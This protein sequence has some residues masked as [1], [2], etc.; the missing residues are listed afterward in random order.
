MSDS[1]APANATNLRRT[2]GIWGV[3]GQSISGVAPTATPTINIALVFAVAG[4]GSWLAYV[5]ATVAILLVA[6]NLVPLAHQFSGAGSLSEFVGQGLGDHARRL[7]AWS[8]LL[9]YLSVSVATL[10]GS[11]GYVSTLFSWAG[12]SMPI[13]AWAAMIGVL[14]VVFALRNIRFS[15]GLMLALEVTSVSLVIALGVVILLRQG[16]T[17]DLS[18]FRLEGLSAGGLNNAL[19][20]GVLSFVGFEAAA[21]LGDEA[22]QPLVTIPRALILT[23][24]LTG[25]FFVFSAYVIVLGFNR[26]A[27]PVASS[28]APLDDLARAMHL[29]GL[30]L[31]VSLGAAI[32]LF[33]CGIATI[34]ASSRLLFSLARQGGI[35]AFFGDVTGRNSLPRLAVATT[36]GIILL[37]LLLMTS[38]AHPLD[39]YDWLGTFGTFGCV[40]AYGL[41][42]VA[43]PVFLRRSGQIKPRHLIVS[44]LALIVLT[45]VLFGSV[46][47]VPAAPMN[48]IPWLFAAFLFTSFGLSTWYSR[49]VRSR[50]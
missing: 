32:S 30:G 34:V 12:F 28:S 46:F 9:A 8:L 33:A 39:I 47:P 40:T 7:T 42:C 44:I 4:S 6:S 14:A 31:L 49:H 1:N 26:Y 43:A 19:L 13:M 17:A 37:S 41:T 27:I 45:Y 2:L 48:L 20:I 38:F 3:M 21:T 5:V 36:A 16:I 29:P 23:P 50:L 15:T 18:Q 11:A 10:A 22:K 35:P 25:V 24:L